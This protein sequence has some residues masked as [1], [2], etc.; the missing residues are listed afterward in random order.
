[1]V[2]SQSPKLADGVRLLAL[3]LADVARLRKVRRGG[4]CKQAHAGANPVVGSAT[5][6]L[7]PMV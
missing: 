7:V 3:V 5:K 1:V 2:G 6:R 4:S